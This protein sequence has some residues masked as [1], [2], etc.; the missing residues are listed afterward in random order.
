MP[1]KSYVRVPSKGPVVEFLRSRMCWPWG[2]RPSG[3]ARGEEVPEAWRSGVRAV[4]ELRSPRS[5]GEDECCRPK[6]GRGETGGSSRVHRGGV[7]ELSVGREGKV[8]KCLLEGGVPS[9]LQWQCRLARWRSRECV[10][11]FFV[12]R[13]RQ[14]HA[15]SESRYV[16][17]RHSA[18]RC[19]VR[20][21]L[22]LFRSRGRVP[23]SSQLLWRAVRCGDAPMAAG[24]VC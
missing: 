21:C 16:G 14:T 8:S 7:R 4:S 20:H 1:F 19:D 2:R 5:L 24:V 3:G 22:R 18:H 15:E 11:Y 23:S 12:A 13:A 10:V 17:S 6:I 9:P